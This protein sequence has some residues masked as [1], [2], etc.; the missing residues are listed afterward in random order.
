MKSKCKKLRK[1]FSI[2]SFKNK[3]SKVKD[4]DGNWLVWN[5]TESKLADL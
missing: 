3:V 5:R 1:K 2:R 4:Y